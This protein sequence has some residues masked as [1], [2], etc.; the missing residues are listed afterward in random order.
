MGLLK[1]VKIFIVLGVITALSA[2]SGQAN[3]APTATATTVDVFMVMTSAAATAFVELT[4]IAGR[5]SETAIPSK[6]PVP[7]ANTPDALV[8][9]ATKDPSGSIAPTATESAVG[10]PVVNTPVPDTGGV[11]TSTLAPSPTPVRPFATT[12]PGVTCLNS[13]YVA[14]V[15]IPDGT[16]LKPYDKFKKIWRIENTGT[17]QWD[18]G[19]GLTIWAGPD[20]GGSPIYFSNNDKPVKPGGVVDLGIEMRAPVT[21]GDYIAHWIMISDSGVT[22]GGDLSIVI[23]VAK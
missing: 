5:P 22:F 11:P 19:F 17:C 4:Q 9:T 18:Q 2:C 16:V 12:A 14:D 3:T 7:P 21:P 1:Y 10:I 13:R 6:T 15:T 23:K 20:M 8:A